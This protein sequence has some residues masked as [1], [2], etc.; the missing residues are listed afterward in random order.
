MSRVVRPRLAW[1]IQIS[2]DGARLVRAGA[3]SVAVAVVTD[4][5]VSAP[6][7]WL[8]PRADVVPLMV[9]VDDESY[10]DGQMPGDLADLLRAGARIT[11]SRPAPETFAAHYQAAI[12]AG[13]DAIVSIHISGE[14]SGTV[15][16]ARIAAGWMSVPVVVV[17]SRVTAMA[18]GF[19]VMAA[20]EVLGGA[21]PGE[22]PA[23]L[24][25]R[26]A[27]AARECAADASINI[28]VDTLE[29]L[30]RGGRI[31]RAQALLGSALAIKPIIAM[32]DGEL[33]AVE[34]VRTSS[35]ALGRVADL[36]V[37]RI[38]EL[39]AEGIEPLVA[40]HHLDATGRAEQLAGRIVEAT[41]VSVVVSEIGPVL[42]AHTGPAV[43][44][45]IVAPGNRV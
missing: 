25:E 1:V 9:H 37:E 34:K 27:N 42:G 10:P 43:V 14:L 44:A 17:D 35:R 12:D 19:A 4:S 26:A 15:D 2:D 28:A 40:V 3:G 41:S 31:G 18:L 7:G 39:L 13:A 20:V 30:Q 38:K 45:A 29:Y 6:L 24:A 22:S 33:D 21:G 36:S 11:T 23:E 5:T 32:I 8:D 16:A